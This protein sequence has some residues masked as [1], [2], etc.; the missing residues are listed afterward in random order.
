MQPADQNRR[1]VLIAQFLLAGT[2]WWAFAQALI[3]IWRATGI[4]RF[5]PFGW[6]DANWASLAI[7]GGAFIYVLRN[8]TAQDFANEVVVELRKVSWPTAKE[9]RSAVIV[10][11]VMVTV[12]SLILG[13]F[14]LIWAKLIKAL[15]TYGSGG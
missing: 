1:Y 12:V 7:V 14:D 11:I 13:T 8:V 2:T 3:L 15:L 5:T 4:P 10:V 6:H 9:T